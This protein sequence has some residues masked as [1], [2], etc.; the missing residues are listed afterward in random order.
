MCQVLGDPEELRKGFTKGMTSL[1]SSLLL[2][3]LAVKI[4]MAVDRISQCY[5][6]FMGDKHMDLGL[7][8]RKHL[9]TV[10][11]KIHNLKAVFIFRFALSP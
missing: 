10:R 7:Y 6:R 3:V 4:T 5:T 2:P 11:I 1:T 8:L 9:C